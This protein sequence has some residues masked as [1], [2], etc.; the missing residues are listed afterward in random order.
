[1]EVRQTRW[2]ISKLVKNQKK[3]NL[4]PMW[5]RGAAWKAQRQVLLIDSIL[6]G[7]DI[8]KVYLRR[9]SPKGVYSYDA[10]DGQQR[11]R[12][13][14]LFGDGELK[15]NHPEGLLEI[16]E[17]LVAG[18]TFD[19][20]HADLKKR[21]KGF[22]VSVAEILS[23]TNDEITN[24]FSRLQMGVSLN[25]AELRNAILKPLRH[26]ID[27][28]AT[29][30]E[31]FLNSR[32]P[33]ARY[34][35][36]DYATHAFAM[37][38]YR[39]QRD[40]KAPDLKRLVSEYGKDDTDRVMEL[41]NKVGQALNVLAEVDKIIGHRLTQKWVFVDLCWLI[42]Q[43]HEVG[44]KVDPTMLARCYIEFDKRRREFNSQPEVLVRGRRADPKLDRQ[45]Y[46]YIVA[47]QKQGGQHPNLRLRNAALRA[48]CPH[49]DRRN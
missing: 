2:T 11:L 15:L 4:N 8:P 5:Q 9:L 24:L 48:F 40:I 34:K 25:P 19:E 3:I 41:S 29:S 36:Q 12:A 47:F 22:V 28:I 23:A 26:V 30:H 45:L 46:N 32:I 27:L 33:E 20:L 44:A 13:M 42:M 6:R 35:R 39:G 7:M 14:W 10:V 37:A 49:I 38:A 16:N 43:R 17:H 1:M 18:L 21:F 31:F